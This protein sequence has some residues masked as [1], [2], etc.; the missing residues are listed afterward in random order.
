MPLLRI[1]K[2]WRG[3]T[4]IEL[5]V[6]IAIIGILIALLLPAVQKVREAAARAQCS[7]NLKQIALA[8]I[9]CADVNQGNIPPAYGS[10][11]KED[12]SVWNGGA[13][14]PTSPPYVHG[15]G[16]G[17][18]K[19]HCLPFMEGND[20]HEK[21]QYY[22]GQAP[23]DPN[24]PGSGKPNTEYRSSWESEPP[25]CVDTTF[26]LRGLAV[27]TLCCPSDPSLKNNLH[28][29]GGWGLSGVSYVDNR[30]VMTENW[31]GTGGYTSYP[32]GLS[33]GTSNTIAYTERY[34]R[35]SEYIAGNPPRWPDDRSFW[36]LRAYFAQGLTGP[37]SKFIIQPTIKYCDSVTSLLND[38]PADTNMYN[39]CSLIPVSPH[40]GGIN[41]AL[42]DGSVK[43]VGAGISP[44]TWWYAC[45]PDQQDLLPGEW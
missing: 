24:P 34:G 1:F 5:L 9:H 11:P 25:K 21:A 44:D 2:R 12:W 29:A 26:E 28:M 41:A 43:F 8:C 42:F 20:I 31:W 23:G 4:L 18:N 15:N 39:I 30:R 16:F 33:D 38:N 36:W 40:P 45:T 37:A 14:I 13:A 3:F 35:I 6:V 7:N 32:A 17:S 22:L 19:F 27:K 10:Y